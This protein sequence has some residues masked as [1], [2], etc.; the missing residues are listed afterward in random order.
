MGITKEVWENMKKV[1][2]KNNG[3]VT[4]AAEELGIPR[5]TFSDRYKK[6]MEIFG[7]QKIEVKEP[8]V[9]DVIEITVSPKK[10]R[11][12]RAH[13]VDDAG[14]DHYGITTEEELRAA[15][16]TPDSYRLVDWLPNAWPSQGANGA[17]PSILHQTKARFAPPDK[18]VQY[19]ENLLEHLKETG[20]VCLEPEAPD[21]YDETSKD[22]MLEISVLDPH[23]N[24]RLRQPSADH[25]WNLERVY[26]L[27]L[28]SIENLLE[29]AS[30]FGPFDTILFPFGHDFFNSDNL[31]NTTTGGTPQPETTEIYEGFPF[32]EE[33]MFQAVDM[34]RPY[35]KNIRLVEVSGNHDKLLSFTFGRVMKARY[36]NDAQVTVD[37]EYA[38]YKFFHWG[39]NLIGMEHGR[40]INQIRLASLMANENRDIWPMIRFPEWHCGDQHRKGTMK[41]IVFEEQGVSIEFLQGLVPANEWSKSKSFNWQKRGGVAFVWDKKQAQIAKLQ[42]HIDYISNEGI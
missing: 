24:L 34:M 25:E 4:H 22:R 36:H 35:A 42:A 20:P 40:N 41:P 15:S 30:H 12:V 26:R 19:Y 33:I 38:P 13:F 16:N 14:I 23:V 8:V 2:H 9:G 17:A 31:I 18:K 1:L 5:K 37:A 3:V 11:G 10:V 27:F 32:S 29:R 28:W 21:G 39:I 7:R 6:G